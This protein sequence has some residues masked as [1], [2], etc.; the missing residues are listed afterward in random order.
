MMSFNQTEPYIFHLI[1]TR[2]RNVEIKCSYRVKIERF[3]KERL[4]TPDL[5]LMEHA[6]CRHMQNHCESGSHP[7][8][9]LLDI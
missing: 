3:I 1:R 9:S 4:V 8:I 7:L 2:V 5:S 6:K